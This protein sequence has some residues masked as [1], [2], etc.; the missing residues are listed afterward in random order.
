MCLF[1]C[2][3]GYKQ[4]GD[5]KGK[6]SFLPDSPCLRQVS[7]QGFLFGRMHR[8]E[9]ARGRACWMEKP[10]PNVGRARSDLASHLP[11]L[12]AGLSSLLPAHGSFVGS[13]DLTSDNPQASYLCSLKLQSGFGSF[14]S[15]SDLGRAIM[16]MAES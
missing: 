15:N 5:S 6:E 3:S 2:C 9:K 11:R 14:V 1:C 13:L 8:A 12:P 4:L 7:D 10:D 16:Y